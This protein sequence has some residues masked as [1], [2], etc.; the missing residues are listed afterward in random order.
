MGAFDD[1]A[2][3]RMGHLRSKRSPNEISGKEQQLLCQQDNKT[4]AGTCGDSISHGRCY[5]C[6]FKDVPN[7]EMLNSAAAGPGMVINK[8]YLF[9]Y[10][11]FF[12]CQL[13][14]HRGA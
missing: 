12:I 2:S 11:Y 8:I 13:Y 14:I 10:F 4:S 6:L 9:T 5:Y 7:T 3:P 1:S